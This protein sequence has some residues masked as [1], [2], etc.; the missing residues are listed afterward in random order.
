MVIVPSKLER[1][2]LQELQ[3]S[4]VVHHPKPATK[5]IPPLNTTS[6]EDDAVPPSPSQ[7]PEGVENISQ[8]TAPLTLAAKQEGDGIPQWSLPSL[9]S[10]KAFFET[11]ERYERATALSPGVILAKILDMK[12]R[13][14]RE[15]FWLNIRPKVS[16][17]QLPIITIHYLLRSSV[18]QVT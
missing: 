2:Q 6:H 4:P 16:Y 8:T 1:N 14:N 18:P 13:S 11:V 17:R 3:Q 5:S 10:E 9:E 7:I 15:R 12:D